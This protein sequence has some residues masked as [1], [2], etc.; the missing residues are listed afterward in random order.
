MATKRNSLYTTS[1]LL[2]L[3]IL[4]SLSFGGKKREGYSDKDSKSNKEKCTKKLNSYTD[5]LC[6]GAGEDANAGE[7]IIDSWDM[8]EK[9][10]R[11]QGQKEESDKMY[12]DL[13]S[14]MEKKGQ[15]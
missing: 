6:M 15:D 7:K 1:A 12:D 13:K 10:L 2:F 14:E 3:V 9:C 5:F 8:G 4:F 11:A